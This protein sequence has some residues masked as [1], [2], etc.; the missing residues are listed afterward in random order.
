MKPTTTPVFA[1]PVHPTP[2]PGR[3]R[4]RLTAVCL[5]VSIPASPEHAG[6]GAS[7]RTARMSGVGRVLAAGAF[8]LTG[9]SLPSPVSAGNQAESSPVVT[10]T[11]A[12]EK[13][14]EL[15]SACL[16]QAG[17]GPEM[18]L[19][20]A[21]DFQMGSPKDETGRYDDESPLHPVAIA[22][23]FAIGRCEVTVGEFRRFVEAT[24]YRSSA[25]RGVGCYKYNAAS[26]K[27]EADSVLNWRQPGFMSYDDRHPVVCVSWDDAQAYIAW[28]N[29]QLGLPPNTYRLPSEAE[30]EYAARA[31]SQA[32]YFWGDGEQCGYTNG[33]D[34]TARQAGNRFFDKNWDYAECSDG[35]V[36]TAP[37]ASLQPNGFGL[38]DTAGNVWE[39]IQDCY[40]DSYEGAPGDGSAW[41][42][43]GC[44]M[45]S[46]RGGGWYGRPSI[47]RSAIRSWNRPDD[48]D[49]NS[50]FRL[51]RT[52]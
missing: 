34:Q 45:R 52:L 40:H 14:A 20:A 39:W 15:R 49:F 23:P 3:R 37:V 51:A 50:G 29:R 28:L 2:G 27:A 7:N 38:Y 17:A 11:P 31:A 33:L 5:W 47:L 9:I 36:F 30:W 32:P 6:K 19:I 24:G 48:S 25:E 41:Q 43:E 16:N 12:K 8:F 46:L 10:T 22:K 21:G 42:Q 18:V 35:F 1:S 44:D 13:N 4:S 26:K